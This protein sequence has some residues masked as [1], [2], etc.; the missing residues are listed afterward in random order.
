MSDSIDPRINKLIIAYLNAKKIVIEQGFRDEIAW[1][2]KVNFMDMDETY[3]LR[4]VAWVVLSSGMREYVIRKKFPQISEAFF[5]WKSAKKINLNKSG[6]KTRALSIFNNPNKISAIIEIS[7]LI[8]M[9]SFTF[10]KERIKNEGVDFIRTL[11]F[12]GPATS[13]HLAKNIG[14]DVVKPDRH[15]VRVTEVW[16]YRT[17]YEMCLAISKES[18]DR[19]SVVDIVIWRFATLCRDYVPFFRN[20]SLAYS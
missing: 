1:Q 12:M 4:E 10:T 16:G 18:G 6:C 2:E 17:P 7:S 11:P 19:I 15:L 9:E 13:Y 20:Y 5:D 8:E 3:F 14:L